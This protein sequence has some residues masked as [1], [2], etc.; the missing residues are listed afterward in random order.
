MEKDE[1]FFDDI[2][3]ELDSVN[4][5]VEDAE[6]KNMLSGKDDDKNCILTGRIRT[7]DKS[8]AR[9]HITIARSGQHAFRDLSF[10]C[11]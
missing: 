3:K 9:N 11:E 4:S 2:R 6:F 5:A 1:S 7:Q 8:P 10:R